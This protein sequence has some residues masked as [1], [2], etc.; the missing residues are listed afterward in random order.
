MGYYGSEEYEI[1]GLFNEIEDLGAEIGCL[2]CHINDM[3]TEMVSLE[4][5]RDSCRVE[6]KKLGVNADEI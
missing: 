3:E 1:N 5:K 4:K 2:Y 6:I